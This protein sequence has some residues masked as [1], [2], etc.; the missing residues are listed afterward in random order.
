VVEVR[1]KR[2]TKVREMGGY[3]GKGRW[4]P[5]WEGEGWLTWII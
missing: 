3:V 1:K 5:T 4:G 2:L